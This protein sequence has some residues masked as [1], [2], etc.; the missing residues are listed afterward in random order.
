MGAGERAERV[1]DDAAATYR[2]IGLPWWAGDLVGADDDASLAPGAP[3]GPSPA[4]PGSSSPGQPGA[5]S[6]V[7]HSSGARSSAARSS[8]AGASD[9][10]SSD[11][12]AALSDAERD[13]VELVVAGLRN[14]EIAARLFLSVRAVESRLT[15]I[16]RKVGV[17]SRAQLVSLL[18]HP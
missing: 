1:R 15:A 7:A 3:A 4:G 12:V 5:R 14:R 11:L 13:V 9:A 18:P 8:G 10:R 16:Y 2:R 17:R 6:S